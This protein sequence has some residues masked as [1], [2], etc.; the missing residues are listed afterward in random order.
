L[1]RCALVP[2]DEYL[3]GFLLLTS[4]LVFLLGS[5]SRLD[6]IK[7]PT[8]SNTCPLPAILT[9]LMNLQ[10]LSFS[11][12]VKLSVDQGQLPKYVYKYRPLN[13]N[14][15]KIFTDSKLWFSKPND[16]NDPFDCQ[17]IVDTNNTENEI[18][19]FLRQNKPSMV[20]KDVKHFSRLWSKNPNDW[21]QMV[22]K[23]IHE[24]VN[25]KGICCFAGNNDN[26]LMW[27][28]YTD[29]HKGICLKFDVTAD[30]DFFSVP[31]IV[32]YSK[33][34]PHYNHLK[35]NSK[36]I[37]FL[38]Q[39]KADIWKY[40]GEIRVLK[41]LSGAY[42]FKKETLVEVC[43]GCNCT[44]SDIQKIKGLVTTSNFKNVA[45]TKAVKTKNY[46]GLEIKQL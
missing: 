42:S 30:T 14:T 37:K 25:E 5:G 40:E 29:S 17:V 4:T 22:N 12:L 8:C 33:D 32:N 27:S 7:Y 44:K 10:E 16:F 38:M 18:A 46:Y 26:I 36:L 13:I 21:H 43:F 2:A 31:F 6:V 35:D 11:E 34:Y 1:H 3:F 28:H 9:E 20:S 24:S 23:T 41:L 19:N 45:F 39:T 15:E